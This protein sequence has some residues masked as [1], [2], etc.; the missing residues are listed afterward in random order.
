M[1]ER[2]QRV[3]Q[4]WTIQGDLRD[5]RHRTKTNETKNTTQQN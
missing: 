1:L 2:T 5:T 3:N 4:E